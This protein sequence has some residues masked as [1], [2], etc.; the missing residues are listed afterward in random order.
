MKMAHKFY[1]TQKK[2][3]IK[4]RS[5]IKFR[6]E[7][8][9]KQGGK[10][11]KKIYLSGEVKYK[12]MKH[13][14]R[15][16]EKSTNTVHTHTHTLIKGHSGQLPVTVNSVVVLA[17]PVWNVTEE[18]YD[19]LFSFSRVLFFLCLREGTIIIIKKKRTGTRII[20]IYEHWVE[21]KIRS[22]TRTLNEWNKNNTKNQQKREKNG[23]KREKIQTL[24][25]NTKPMK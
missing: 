19:F 12:M 6:H 20:T 7:Q 17:S 23:T 5:W 21:L 10:K 11:I 8:Q 3:Q 13:C 16:T 1:I 14:W 22:E 9:S 15:K 24:Y 4:S 18:S 25:T 2:T